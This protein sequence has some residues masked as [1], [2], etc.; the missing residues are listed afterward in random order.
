MHCFHLI[1]IY[2]SDLLSLSRNDIKHKKRHRCFCILYY[3]YCRAGCYKGIH[4]I[5][6][7]FISRL[8]QTPSVLFC[9][10]ILKHS[11]SSLVPYLWFLLTCSNNWVVSQQNIDLSNAIVTSFLIIFC[12]SVDRLK[13]LFIIVMKS[14]SFTN[15]SQF[16]IRLTRSYHEWT[17]INIH[18]EQQP[19][20]N[21]L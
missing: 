11:V 8:L 19:T 5:C 17:F 12:F 4:V 3:L 9:N 14:H 10:L 1:R 20:D 7:L 18:K 2:Y 16:E 15:Y 13:V 6:P 21:D